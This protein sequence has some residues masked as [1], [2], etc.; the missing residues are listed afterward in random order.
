MKY[1]L[2]LGKFFGIK[3]QIHWTFLILLGWIIFSNMRAGSGAE[4]TLWSV[5]FILSIFVCVTLHEFGHALAAKRFGIKTKDITL[6]PIGGLAR[7]E[8][9][10]EKPKEELIVALAGPL[11]NI[12]IVAALY[13]LVHFSLDITSMVQLSSITSDNFIFNLMFINLW[14][15]VFNLIPAFPMDG[16]RVLRAVLSFKM[17]RHKATRIAAS[18]GQLLSIGFVILG[19]F[20]NPFLI[21]IGFFIFLGAQ[22]EAEYTQAKSMLK[23]FTVNDVLM[24]QYQTIESDDT[25]KSAVQL[26]LNGQCKNFLVM[27][28][29]QPV[30]TL[31]R[32][33]IIKALSEQS[34][35]AVIHNVM[36]KELLFLKAQMPLEEAWHLMQQ[37]KTLMPVFTNNKLVGTL[38]TENILEFIMIKNAKG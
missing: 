37:H 14:L 9:I 30:G 34:E 31:S 6:L 22:A 15:A 27:E 13:P 29:Q 1:S 19:F 12:I 11:V 8:S 3:V 26:L 16:G 5:L 24:K 38:D 33:E 36:N 18:I 28:N 2:Q 23:G 20:G 10:P 25:I 17:E 32:D 7:L 4:Q 21:F 35:N